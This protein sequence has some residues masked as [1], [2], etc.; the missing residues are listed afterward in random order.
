MVYSIYLDTS[1]EHC[2]KGQKIAKHLFHE[3]E[4][5]KLRATRAKNVLTCQRALRAYL[6]T[7]LTCLRAHVPTCLA[8]LRAN[9]S[10]VLTR[11]RALRAYMLTCQRALRAYVLKCQRALR[12]NWQLALCAH[13]QKVSTGLFFIISSFFFCIIADTSNALGFPKV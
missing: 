3:N 4:S 11:Q 13:V 5:A 7:C 6:P 8:C 9:V 12:A 2:S 10:C 1:L